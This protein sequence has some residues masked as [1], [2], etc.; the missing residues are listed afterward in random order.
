MSAED[1]RRFST[2]PFPD[3]GP[4][5][6][7]R[8]RWAD[9]IAAASLLGRQEMGEFWAAIMEDR[10]L[11]SDGEIIIGLLKVGLKQA[12]GIT[13][14]SPDWN[15]LPFT[16]AAAK[17]PLLDAL[18]RVVFGKSYAELNAAVA[19]QLAAISAQPAMQEG[20]AA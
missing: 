12:D 6:V 17:L 7:I 9:V 4:G 16:M 10:V 18:F 20:E 5:V 8:F 3:A 2:V 11:L 14:S 1:H 13:P 19:Q 15:D